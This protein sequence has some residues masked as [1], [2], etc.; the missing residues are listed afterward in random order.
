MDS[1]GVSKGFSFIQFEKP[2]AAAAAFE[3]LDGEPFQGRLIQILPAT[4]KKDN[5]I[6][7]F[8]ISKLPLKKQKEIK[9]KQEAGRNQW[10]WNSLYMSQDAVN[11]SMANRLGVSKSELL[12]P[13]SADAGVKQAIAETSIIQE[14]KNYFKKNGVDLEAFKRNEVG[15]TAI[16]AKN[17]PY[18]TSLEELRTMFEEYGQ[19]VRVLMP[20]TGTIAIV[21]FAQAPQARAAYNGLAYRKMGAS[22]LFLQKAPRDLFKGPPVADTSDE[23]LTSTGVDAKV[24]V[25]DL[26]EGQQ[27]DNA[28]S[29]SSTLF[30]RNLAFST[31][32]GR[33][34][35]LF[36]PLNGFLSAKVKTK[37]DAKR[38]GQILSMGFGFVEFQSKADASAALNA[39]NGYALDGHK[40]LIKSSHK[41]LDA[42]EERKKEDNAKKTAGKRTKVIVKNLPFEASKAD[43]RSLLG[44]Y[45]KLRSVRVPKKFDNS[46]R[47]FAFAEFVSPR[48]AENALSQLSGTHLLGRHLVIEY[49]SEDVIDAE[50]E[51]EKM[52]SKVGKQVKKVELQKLTGGGRKRFDIQGD[53]DDE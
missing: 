39:M 53:G 22:M 48:E 21:E 38:P 15:D 29:E 45:G 52:Q 33:L 32:T 8:A 34:T 9:R 23:V 30:V 2:E 42:V 24:S 49:A 43:V 31:S 25:D 16:L 3:N 4:S 37:T 7:E 19:V 11:A 18:G 12:D 50:E 35:E 40:L 17:F 27:G 10:T 26:L 46:A 1:A 36:K 13:T 6:D 44:N 41:G 20:S 51:I 5:K 47:G 28:I 14:A